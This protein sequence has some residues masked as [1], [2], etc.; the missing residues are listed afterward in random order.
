MI[1]AE[2]HDQKA[3]NLDEALKEV[4]TGWRTYKNNGYGS[5]WTILNK[6]LFTL[7]DDEPG[8]VFASYEEGDGHGTGKIVVIAENY[9]IYGEG[10]ME[11]MSFKVIPKSH[12]EGLE[13]LTAKR[14]TS[15]WADD[16]ATSAV[17]SF[18][19]GFDITLPPGDGLT[20]TG[21]TYLDNQVIQFKKRLIE[22]AS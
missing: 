16:V 13:I 10:A 20:P 8:A 22:P 14:L 12:F 7:G 2:E 9:L 3:R 1:T 5:K 21:Q 17:L 18:R 6:I 15:D 19:N 4:S 11:T